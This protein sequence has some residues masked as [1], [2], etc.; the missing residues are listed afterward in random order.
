MRDGKIP[1]SSKD[2]SIPTFD[3]VGEKEDFKDSINFGVMR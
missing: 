1:L 2:V 3:T